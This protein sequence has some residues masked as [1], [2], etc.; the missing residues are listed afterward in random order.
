MTL[1]GLGQLSI[2]CLTEITA[3][4]RRWYAR[5]SLGERGGRRD[6]F[7]TRCT[8]RA[9]HRAITHRFVPALWQAEAR[10]TTRRHVIS[11]WIRYTASRCAT[12]ELLRVWTMRRCTMSACSSAS[13]S[14]ACTNI[15][16]TRP[17]LTL[18]LG[19]RLP[20]GPIHNNAHAGYVTTSAGCGP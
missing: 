8:R 20:S 1:A 19:P 14:I 4:L 18:P 3:R 11:S 7:Q 6:A 12:G 15:Q 16:G 9:N 10:V 13:A 5:H 2:A 17:A